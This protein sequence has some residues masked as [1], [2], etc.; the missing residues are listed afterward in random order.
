[1]GSGKGFAQRR[2][3]KMR[4]KEEVASLANKLGQ[5]SMTPQIGFFRKQVPAP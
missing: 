1:M 4:C 3:R 5:G 2:E